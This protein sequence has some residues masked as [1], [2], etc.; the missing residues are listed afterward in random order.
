MG[1]RSYIGVANDTENYYTLFMYGK[2]YL[3]EYYRSEPLNVLINTY[4]NQECTFHSIARD[5]CYQIKKST[6]GVQGGLLP[7]GPLL[8][9][10]WLRF[11]WLTLG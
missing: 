8:S 3:Q 10:L 7:C 11:P 9:A 4:I 1:M 5:F 6:F 2:E